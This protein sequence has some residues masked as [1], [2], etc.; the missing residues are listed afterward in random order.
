L[1]FTSFTFQRFFQSIKT[2]HRSIG[3]ELLSLYTSTHLT[4]MYQSLPAAPR[5]MLLNRLILW[6]KVARCGERRNDV[7][8][9]FERA[10][11]LSSFFS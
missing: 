1:Q 11:F 4:L 2:Y 7:R 5:I 6:T 8:E 9:S 10:F 3:G